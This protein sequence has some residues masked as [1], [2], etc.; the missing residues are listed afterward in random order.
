MVG[1]SLAC[2]IFVSVD[3]ETGLG[4][5]IN[6][7]LGLQKS[8]LCQS[9]VKFNMK[10]QPFTEFIVTC[11]IN[12]GVKIHKRDVDTANGSCHKI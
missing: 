9:N 2:P 5:F 10:E 12:T 4:S 1:Y 7:S 6:H 3:I 8:T 11:N